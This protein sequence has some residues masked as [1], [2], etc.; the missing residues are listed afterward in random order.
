M[1]KLHSFAFYAL[2]AP[3]I[4]LGAG[5]AL[6]AQSTDSETTK[7]QG[8]Q[9]E[10]GAK[11]SD[12]QKTADRAK[13]GEQS[14]SQ[15]MADPAKT[16]EQSRKQH[17]DFL[18]SAPA[19]G[20]QASNLIG[21]EIKTTGDENLGEVLDLVIGDEGQV[22]A[23]VVSVGGFLGMGE[24]NVAIGWDNL[25]KS[26]ASDDQ[27]MRVDVTRDELDSAPEFKKME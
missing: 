4:T 15:E 14:D 24:K 6:A 21:T 20:V 2:A 27:Q 1:K 23:I 5:S 9:Q 3:I 10:Q 16:G 25:M 8:A 13:T 17:K 7:N 11:Q 18:A 22:M 26:G 12:S 19:N